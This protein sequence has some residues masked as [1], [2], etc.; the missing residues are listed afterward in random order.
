LCG[1]K[2]LVQQKDSIPLFSRTA[3]KAQYF[4]WQPPWRSYS[5]LLYQKGTLKN[6]PPDFLEIS[7]HMKKEGNKPAHSATISYEG[8][9]D[10]E[11]F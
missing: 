2:N 7:F 6:R 11:I 10:H 3:R 4:Q 1:L 5:P 8:N 9:I